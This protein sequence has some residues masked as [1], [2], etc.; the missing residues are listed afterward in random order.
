MPCG[1]APNSPE[2]KKM[3]ECAQCG[4]ELREDYTYF[5][6]CNGN[7]FCSQDCAVD[8]NKI[9]EKEWN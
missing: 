8:F 2:P 1:L 4:Y 9:T 7:K 6:D 3:G 5:E